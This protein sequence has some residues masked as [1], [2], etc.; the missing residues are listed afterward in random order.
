MAGPTAPKGNLLPMRIHGKWYDMS[1]FDHPGGPIMLKLGEG[2]DASAMFEA[3]HPFTNRV[4]LERLLAKHQ[5]DPAK[6]EDC[7]LFDKKDQDPFFDWPQAD[8]K[9]SDDFA[10][11]APV[12]E[13]AHEMTVR[14]R[15]Y[16]EKEA[17]RRGVPLLEASKATPMR[18]LSIVVMAAIYIST[19]PSFFAGEYWTLLVTPFT[20]WILGV[21]TFHDGSHF[22]LSRNWRVNALATYVGYYFSSPLEWYHQHVIGHH[23]YPNI[24]HRD[25]DLYHNGTFERH[26]KTLRHRPLHQYQRYTWYPIWFIGTM[27]M[28][29][30]K[31]LQTWTSGYYNRA[32]A[33]LRIS[34][35]R[36]WTHI[37]GR[38][39]VFFFCHVWPFMVFNTQ[40]A[41][42][43]SILPTGMV[44]V[45]FMMCS[46][47]NH[48]T[49]EN[50]DVEDTDY[51]KHQVLTSHSFTGTNAFTAWFTFLFTGGLNLQIEHHLFPT[52]N[53]CH[54]P[55]IQQI[56]KDVCKKH[57]VFYHESKSWGHAMEKYLKHMDMLS[58]PDGHSHSH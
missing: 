34:K 54:L 2:R 8:L 13:F 49:A 9:N 44:S 30:L 46:Q 29:Y 1:G 22:S 31:P 52:V 23:A 6:T 5:V 10:S 38:A 37:A 12:T 19:L 51:Y 24:P 39:I 45:F 25:P 57:D 33:V 21:N 50:I 28:N 7:V 56:V 27:A 18:W 11:V 55:Y 14:V 42:L 17:K 43:F 47:V 32:V 40:K 4:Y 15:G 36:L 16:L 20:Y 53:H 58:L 3:H 26:T 35:Q 48:L 41:L